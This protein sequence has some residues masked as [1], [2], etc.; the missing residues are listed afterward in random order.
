[1][2]DGV[3]VSHKINAFVFA[4]SYQRVSMSVFKILFGIIGLK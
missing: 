1:M 4:L 3:L 2:S